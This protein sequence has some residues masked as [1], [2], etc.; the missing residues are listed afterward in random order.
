MEKPLNATMKPSLEETFKIV[1]ESI[2]KNKTLIV[3]GNCEIEYKGRAESKLGLGER[4]LLI[5]N[6]GAVLIH[7]P[8]G[9]EPVNWQPSG[10]IFHSRLTETGLVIRATNVKTKESLKLTFTGVMFATQLELKDTSEFILHASE[11]DMQK[12]I[13]L[14][15][16]L[17]EEGFHP[18]VK[19][20]KTAPGFVDIFGR[21]KYGRFVVVEIKRKTANKDAVLQLWKYIQTIGETEQHIRGILVAPKLAKNAGRLLRELN[22]EFKQLSPKKCIETLRKSTSG[23]LLRY[24]K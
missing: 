13:L 24:M 11:E 15:P 8:T 1:Q 18:I 5:K 14:K 23:E 12:A 9:Y 2:A 7:R 20:K 19:E 16:E 3:V 10:C 6:D 17:V 21:D 4:I 22:L